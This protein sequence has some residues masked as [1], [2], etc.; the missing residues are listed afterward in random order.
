MDAMETLLT[1]RSIRRYTSQ[2]VPDDVLHAILEAA[3]SAPSASNEQAWQ[4]IVVNDH[5]VMQD[6]HKLH[7]YSDALNEA[8]VAILVCGDLD[9]QLSKGFWVQDCSAATE[10]LLLAAH[11]KG[12]GAVWMG[13]YPDEA[14]SDK[15]RHLLHAPDTI[16]PFALVALGYPAEHIP[17]AQ[18]FDSQRVHIN[19]W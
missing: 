16:V 15:L 18:R 8:T 13:V 19:H 7:P 5:Q 6:V 9:R 3:M 12:L 14:R 11:A 2:A 1:R 4:F 10:N 17:P